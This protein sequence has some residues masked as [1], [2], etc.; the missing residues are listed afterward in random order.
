MAHK[1]SHGVSFALGCGVG[2]LLAW[3]GLRTVSGAGLWV[4]SDMVWFKKDQERV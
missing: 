1:L 2:F 4:G 3:F